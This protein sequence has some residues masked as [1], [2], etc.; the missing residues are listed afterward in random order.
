MSWFAVIPPMLA[1]VT[2]MLL[3]G[4]PVALALRARGITLVALSLGSSISTI[5]V[6]GVLA[7]LVGLGWQPYTPFLVSIPLAILA[8]LLRRW[9]LRYFPA[10]TGRGEWRLL[11]VGGLPA[12]FIAALLIAIPLK[13]GIGR[14]DW[15]SQTYDAIFHLNSVQQIL[16]TGNGSTLALNLGSPGSAF[17]FYPAAW[18]DVVSLVVQLSGVEIVVAANAVTFAIACISWPIS[19]LFLARQ[20]F[21]KQILAL[22]LTGVLSSA[23]VAFPLLMAQYGVLYPY[24]LAISLTPVAV[25]LLVMAA[26]KSSEPGLETPARW[27]MLGWVL[28]GLA[29]AH[30][31]A[32]F[33]VMVIA[34][35]LLVQALVEYLYRLR[36]DSRGRRRG[37]VV[38][39][40]FLA[41]CVACVIAWQFARTSDD[42][43][44]PY[45]TTAQAI[46]AALLNAPQDR[47][48]ILVPSALMV[49]GISV[50]VRRKTHLWV[51]FSWGLLVFLFVVASSWL[52]SPLRTAFVGLWY[53]NSPRL[54]A[55][56]PIMALPLATEGGLATIRWIQ[57]R[58]LDAQ[59]RSFASVD[60][61][62]WLAVGATI[63]A[64]A[65]V[66]PPAHGNSTRAA[67]EQLAEAYQL[68]DASAVLTPDELTMFGR[69]SAETPHDAVIAGNPWNGSGL[70]Y[71]YTDRKALF[72]H[73][74]GSWSAD[75]WYVAEHLA[76][77][78]P[79][80]CNAV[81]K[82]HVT[83]VLDFGQLYLFRGDPRAE[84]YPGFNNLETSGAVILV[85]KVGMTKLYKVTAC[86]LA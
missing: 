29:V 53:N 67:E 32:P 57:K 4:V 24:L 33:A 55:L 70:V 66:V 54:M 85:D 41:A 74:A 59:P 84:K 58:L 60:Y 39:V 69:V 14:P 13:A 2:V 43:W 7:P 52:P 15:P 11:F 76:Q 49:I 31:S 28:V 37:V 86:G 25:G 78:S 36:A 3:P 38:T 22:I 45:Q 12:G 44:Q 80:L 73:V 34:L 27:L 10:N 62:R 47:P 64:V 65:A 50:A 79:E 6:A 68:S 48:A 19:C 82:Y 56:L 75:R 35:P 20:L 63:L 40:L 9:W 71:A 81:R 46:G 18:H 42:A 5:V 51:A 23:F 8:L 83:Y 21:G 17:A 61:R 1:A 77:A 26:G 30:P 72:P 16:D